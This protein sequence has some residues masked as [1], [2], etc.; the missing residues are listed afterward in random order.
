MET[1]PTKNILPKAEQK[2]LIEEASQLFRKAFL[3]DVDVDKIMITGGAAEGR[4]GEY[5]VPLGEK[6]GNRMVSDIDGVAIVED[7]Y[8]PNSEW[9]LVAKRD[10]W[11]VYRIGEVAEKYPVE[12][13]ILRRSS[14][15]KKK[16][17]ERGEF[18]GIP[19]TSDTKNKFIVIYERGPK[20]Q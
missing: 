11:E 3:P 7:G 6:Y 13:L 18:Y 9:K 16:V 8:K 4:L 17:V 2:K 19:M 10:F 1:R 5:D 14:I 15:V 12:C 20:R